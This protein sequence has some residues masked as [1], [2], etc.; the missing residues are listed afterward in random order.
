[1]TEQEVLLTRNEVAK[2][3]QLNPH[4]LSMW[5]S[6]GKN[7]PFIKIGRNVRYKVKDVQ[8]YIERNRQGGPG[9]K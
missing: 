6:T 4:T 3:L 1:M 9:A 8:D 5:G 2:M 7:I